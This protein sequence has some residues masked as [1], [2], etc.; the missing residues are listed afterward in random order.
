[1]KVSKLP[2]LFDTVVLYDRTDLIAEEAGRM[3]WGRAIFGA[4]TMAVALGCAGVASTALPDSWFHRLIPALL[5]TAIAV[6]LIRPMRRRRE[7]G[8]TGGLRPFLVGLAVTGGS[9]ALMLGAGTALG[10]IVWGRF[11]LGAVLLFLLTNGVIAIL[12][13][14]FP[15]ELTLRGHTYSA[16]RLTLRPWLAAAGTTFLFLLVPGG[17]SLVQYLLSSLLGLEASKPSL[18]P[19]GE[20][21]FSYFFLLVIFGITLIAA[22]TATGSLW[23]AVATHLTLL[24]INRLTLLGDDRDSGWSA[25]LVQP[26]AILLI[27][28]YLLL[29]ATIYRFALSSRR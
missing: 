9:G 15:E 16:L 19:A 27:P 28:G 26:D 23:T 20:D 14:A 6:L 5:C 25:E 10:W 13:E 1:V 22:R 21:P 11:E 8:L 7:L 3:V 29:A 12:L 17:S 2:D 24:T 4:L 18:A